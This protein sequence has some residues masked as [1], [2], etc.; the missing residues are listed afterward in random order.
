MPGPMNFGGICMSKKYVQSMYKAL[1]QTIVLADN[2][3][4]LWKMKIHL[5]IKIFG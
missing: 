5:M 3:K 1:V 4:K 2:N